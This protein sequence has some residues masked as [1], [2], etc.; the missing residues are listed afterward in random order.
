MNVLTML[1]LRNRVS[2]ALIGDDF[3]P[4]V[5][6]SPTTTML[7]TKKRSANTNCEGIDDE[8]KKHSVRRCSRNSGFHSGTDEGDEEPVSAASAP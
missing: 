3:F 1:L 7:Q 2:I 8:N 4:V 6:P 5:L